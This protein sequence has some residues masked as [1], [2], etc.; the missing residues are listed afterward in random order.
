MEPA[1]KAIDY[2][3]AHK[4]QNAPSFHKYFETLKKRLPRL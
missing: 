2:L 4:T 3:C 1:H